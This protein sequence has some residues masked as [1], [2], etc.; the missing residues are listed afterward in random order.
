MEVDMTLYINP[1]RGGNRRRMVEE[2]MRDWDEGY[3]AELTFPIDVRADSESFT[4]SALLP[5]LNPEDLDI[6]IVNEIVTI[7]G[8]LNVDRPEGANY[9]LAE[10][11]SGRFHRVIN[12][13][14]PLD[15]EK[16]EANLENGI[17]TLYVPKAEE[18]KP[19][20][21]KVVQK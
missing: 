20:T 1:L 12:L 21:I 11:P 2:M 18:A 5:G 7:S 13:P 9:L 17:L 4:I 14:T 16:V 6:Q 10:R 19:R 3:T 15:A 8:E